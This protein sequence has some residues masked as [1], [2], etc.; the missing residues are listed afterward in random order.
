[1]NRAD[2][3]TAVFHPFRV[4]SRRACRRAREGEVWR[5]GLPRPKKPRL[6]KKGKRLLAR[7]PCWQLHAGK[8]S[9]F[10][11][12]VSWVPRCEIFFP[13]L[14]PIRIP[15]LRA[16]RSREDDVDEIE[17]ISGALSATRGQLDNEEGDAP[18]G[19]DNTRASLISPPRSVE[20]Q[21]RSW[22]VPSRSVSPPPRC[23]PWLTPGAPPPS[24]PRRLG[25][26]AV[27]SPSRAP[28]STRALGA[29][30]A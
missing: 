22:L 12:L 4:A 30:S 29:S 17:E 13:F 23:A 10:V 1:M 27:P 26:I 15:R 14:I 19:Q 9:G 2:G 8:L 11:S 5:G 25:P 20:Y 6:P 16:H 18:R 28:A 3:S 21:R 24:G 7:W